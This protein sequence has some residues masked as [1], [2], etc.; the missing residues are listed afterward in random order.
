MLTLVAGSP[1]VLAAEYV[2]RAFLTPMGEWQR[3]D[4]AMR[5]RRLPL[6]GFQMLR[7]PGE[8]ELTD[9]LHV[10]ARR[11]NRPEGIEAEAALRYPFAWL[12]RDRVGE[13]APAPLRRLYDRILA[14]T[15]REGTTF[16]TDG[17]TPAWGLVSDW[18]DRPVR[19]PYQPDAAEVAETIRAALYDLAGEEPA[20]PSPRTGPAPPSP[21]LPPDP[22]RPFARAAQEEREARRSA[23][24]SRRRAKEQAAAPPTPI[25]A[26]ASRGASPQASGS[27]DAA[28]SRRTPVE[29]VNFD[30]YQMHDESGAPL[31]YT[32]RYGGD[33]LRATDLVRRAVDGENLKPGE[34]E[35]VAMAERNPRGPREYLTPDWPL[36]PLPPE[37]PAAHQLPHEDRS[38]RTLGLLPEWGDALQF[39]PTATGLVWYRK[40]KKAEW[41]VGYVMS[42]RTG[43]GAVRSFG[44]SRQ[45]SR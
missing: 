27:G 28:P 2:A 10:A 15:E 18:V 26:S 8:A 42:C 30:P 9:L 44:P 3:R 37:S 41:R 21:L 13:Y 11:T 36:G 29:A 23:A 19:E 45:R 39:G 1:V 25:P 14:R 38:P 34:Y 43:N 33:D 16:A 20:P 32:I 24:A 17:A 7:G 4:W 22:S 6:D 5:G 40:G 12:A 31:R 35:V